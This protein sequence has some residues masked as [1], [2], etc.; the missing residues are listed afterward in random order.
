MQNKT[1]NLNKM[2]PKA[3]TVFLCV[4]MA[5]GSPI[6]NIPK[7]SQSFFT[8][9]IQTMKENSGYFYT[10]NDGTVCCPTSLQNQPYACQLQM[11]YEPGEIYQDATH[12]RTRQSDMVVWFGDVMKEMLLKPAS[13]SSQYA[14]ECAA[15]CPISKKNTFQSLTSVGN[16]GPEPTQCKGKNAPANAGNVTVE[17]AR[18]YNQ[19]MTC[20][21]VAWTETLLGYPVSE[22]SMYIDTSSDENKPFLFAS[23]LRP[24]GGE[25]QA[26][27]NLS[28]VNWVAKDFNDKNE[29]AFDIDPASI[30]KCPIDPNGGCNHPQGPVN[31]KFHRNLS[32]HEYYARLN[33]VF[34]KS[35]QEQQQRRHP[36]PSP[37][38]LVSVG[39]YTP[40]NISFPLDWQSL[41]EYEN[42]VNKGGSVVPSNYSNGNDICC[43][44]DTPEC[45]VAYS[46]SSEYQYYDYTHQR[47]R[48]ERTG[49]D[50]TDIVDYTV[51]RKYNV[52]SL[53]GIET[54]IDYCPLKSGSTIMHPNPIDFDYNPVT[55]MGTTTWHNHK[56]NKYVWYNAF[57]NHSLPMATYTLFVDESNATSA[58]PLQQ[59]SDETPFNQTRISRVRKTW[60]KFTP[61]P[62]SAEK[63][64]V[65]K[66][67]SCPRAPKC[68]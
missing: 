56:A 1:L 66:L 19:Q 42:I 2:I 20:E 40:P 6:Q 51:K 23:K 5:L 4:T 62:I 46:Q 60:T 17:R 41:I 18:P 10:Q 29:T 12:N 61:G 35:A 21:N 43:A 67:D 14:W 28:Y 58:V 13:A 3:T 32:S 59:F 53:N 9:I 7:T 36:S 45:I 15:Y 64:N 8:D 26:V 50:E 33:R 49:L 52:R 27:Q 57:F 11:S 24:G 30:Q 44:Y 48:V 34:A 54:C 37:P 22:N 63:F 38:S 55:N 39:N 25:V 16:C 31:K 65:A 68:G 47:L